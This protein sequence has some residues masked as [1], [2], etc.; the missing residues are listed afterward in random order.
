M[1]G[2]VRTVRACEL[3][4]EK[5]KPQCMA[6]AARTRASYSTSA[7]RGRHCDQASLRFPLRLRVVSSRAGRRAAGPLHCIALRLRE[8]ACTGGCGV[9]L[10]LAGARAWASGS[11]MHGSRGNHATPRAAWV[12]PAQ[13]V[14]TWS[15]TQARCVACAA[16]LAVVRVAG[17]RLL[18][19]RACNC[20]Y[21]AKQSMLSSFS[22]C[23]P[24]SLTFVGNSV[25]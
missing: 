9:G 16:C 5:A 8:F 7:G 18:L 6:G 11:G 12:W 15:T 14:A 21:D 19:I 10:G 23:R 2:I 1:G 17:H 3:T 25:C 22:L 4:R 24:P 13:A 20:A